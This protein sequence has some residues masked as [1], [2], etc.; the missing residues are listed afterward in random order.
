MGIGL[1]TPSDNLLYVFKKSKLQLSLV[2]VTN[3]YT[4]EV[5]EVSN[6]IP[7]DPK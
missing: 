3:L 5:I 2:V 1:N 7:N 6:H 4:E